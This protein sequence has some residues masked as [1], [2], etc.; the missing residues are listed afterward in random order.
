MEL[1]NYILPALHL[2]NDNAIT[3]LT[4]TLIEMMPGQW[5]VTSGQLTYN[6]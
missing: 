2:A 6:S 5:K 1:S 4:N 3:W